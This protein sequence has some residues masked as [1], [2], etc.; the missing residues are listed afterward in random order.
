MF[1]PT[2]D[3][4]RRLAH[5]QFSFQQCLFFTLCVAFAIFAYK[6][7]GE[8]TPN[9]ALLDAAMLGDSDAIGVLLDNGAN[10]DHRDAW[11]TTALGLAAAY[12]HLE[13]VEL[14]LAH[15]ANPDERIREN[16]T[17]LIWAAEAGQIEI[18][19]R[20]LVYGADHALTDDN[21]FTAKQHSVNNGHDA[22][23]E[24][25]PTSDAG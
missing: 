7:C 9:N 13:C 19:K 4:D 10:I 18:V 8:S 14:L 15:G 21:G 3:H 25:F 12:G 1:T 6:G 22:I 2:N 23:A 24:L 5:N 11:H 16:K 20:L 17:A